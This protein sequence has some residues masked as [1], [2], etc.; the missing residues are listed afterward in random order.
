MNQ[1]SN[2]W[3]KAANKAYKNG[4]LEKSLGL[5]T[6]AS[7]AYPEIAS[8]IQYSIDAIKK[9]LGMSRFGD[10]YPATVKSVP[11]I[12]AD[13]PKELK[14]PP[15]KGVAND[16]SH[17]EA[18]V[19]EYWKQ[20]NSYNES[21]SIIIPVYN[22]LHEVD[23]V[24]AGLTHQSYPK[25]LMEIVLADDGSQ[26]SPTPLI[27]KYK[28]NLTIKYCRQDDQGYRLSAA[29][30][31]GIK[32]ASHR[33]IIILDSDAIPA[34]N[35]VEAYMRVLH[36]RRDVAL[37]GLRHYVTTE[38]FQPADLEH[39]PNV[40]KEMERV[41][42]ENTVTTKQDS[43]GLSLDWRIDHFNK[44]DNLKRE[45]LPYRFLVGANC[46]FSREL[47]EKAGGYSEDFQAWGFEDQEFG[48]RLL[49]Q[50]AYFMPLLNA[51]VYHQEPLAGK[52]D[53]DR[54]LGEATTKRIFV[55]KCPFVHRKNSLEAP[56]FE[57]PLVSIYIPLFNRENYIADCIQSALEQTV[58]DLEIV[59]CN[60][61][62]T[63]RS[64]EI[65]EKYY[66]NNRRVRLITQRNAGIGAASNTAVHACKGYY[67]GQLDAD[68]L[69]KRDAV[70]QCLKM[71]EADNS[72]SL[73]Y[74]TTEYIDEH[75]NVT[76]EG[77]NWPIFSREH[78][79]TKMICHHFRFFRRRDWARTSGFNESIKNAV[80]YDMMLKLA[81]VGN[82]AHINRVLYSY[83]KHQATT[84]FQDNPTQTANNFIAINDSLK[85]L[86]IKD[87]I[88]VNA[89]T[90]PS[91]RR[92]KFIKQ[93]SP[94]KP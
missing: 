36:V 15:L 18:E 62:S 3:I 45:T 30:N 44:T 83:R 80:D 43:S 32:H 53:T 64:A 56:P 17:I 91:E 39:S 33:N 9:K 59:I 51:Y 16:H 28:H 93:D 2:M 58:K 54:K 61:G 37:F 89:G 40:L 20:K 88:A 27:E 38:G 86:S 69:L 23:F 84:T 57:A 19:A 35:L 67:I 11:S 7:S 90:S 63:D 71:M 55:Q 41:K 70:E 21:V 76:Q 34:P 47:H 79:L 52:N 82:I 13:W 22:R 50:G 65:V 6:Q 31:L 85:R 73:V 46:G 48:Y 26:E 87:F 78:L 60:D 94:A 77:W 66:S 5:F 72:L 10:S 42:S 75:S 12:P 1:A 25:E 14:L 92:T 68:D 81:E 4:D 49:L 74:G 29:R 8:T 24:L